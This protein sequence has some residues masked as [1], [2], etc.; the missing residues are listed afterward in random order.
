M[1]Q[2]EDRP[3]ENTGWA[4]S[5]TQIEPNRVEIA[6]HP[7]R[8]IV[9]RRSLPEATHLLI[10]KEFPKEDQL[11]KLKRICF[12]AAA[13]SPP[14]VVPLE[15]EPV[16]RTLARHILADEQI[17]RHPAEDAKGECRKAIFCLGRVIRFIG[18]ILGSEEAFSGTDWN[19][20]F[21]HWLYRLFTKDHNVCSERARMLEALVV[22]CIDH[23]FTPP[24][25]QICV[26]AASARV[27]YEV[28]VAQGVSAI[29]HVHGGA[30]GQAA[31]FFSSFLTKKRDTG[32]GLQEVLEKLMTEI[33]A[34]GRRIPGLGHRVHTADPRCDVLW[35]VAEQTA[36]A[37]ECVQASKLT[38]AIFSRIRGRTLPTNVDGVIGAIAADMELPPV[39]ATLVFVLG[40]IA[41]LSAHYFEEIRL[42]PAMRWVNFGEAIYR[43]HPTRP[44]SP[45]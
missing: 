20:P 10:K 2:A 9:I 4:T 34:Q 45:E 40:R 1:R 19:E 24:S 22:A 16:S 41:G 29:S 17:A 28:A 39:I 37:R 26:L 18:S 30:S 38:A 35:A 31:Q 27:P 6:G 8:D 42:F 43:G 11:R 32:M 44:T 3:S 14:P 36:V 25:T 5:I 15:D 21:S 23:G 12:E 13:L 33:L 7:I